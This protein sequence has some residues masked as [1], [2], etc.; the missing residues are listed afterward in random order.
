M[1][2]KGHRFCSFSFWRN[3]SYMFPLHPSRWFEWESNRSVQFVYHLM[4]K[5]IEAVFISRI[6][7]LYIILN[8]YPDLF[9]TSD[10]WILRLEINELIHFAA[11]YKFIRL[12]MVARVNVK[13]FTHSFFFAFRIRNFSHFLFDVQL[14]EHFSLCVALWTQYILYN[15]LSKWKGKIRTHKHY[16]SRKVLLLI[17]SSVW[18]FDIV[19]CPLLNHRNYLINATFCSFVNK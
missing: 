3:T 4:Q 10:V 1:C 8:C 6:V 16:V 15:L 19:T 5:K 14:D 18:C 12:Q 9:R 7:R 13:R 2:S 17:D 11:H